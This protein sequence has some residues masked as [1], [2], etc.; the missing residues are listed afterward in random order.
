MVEFSARFNLRPAADTREIV[1]LWAKSNA[2]RTG[3]LLPE[4]K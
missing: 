4:P 2:L 3:K 1:R